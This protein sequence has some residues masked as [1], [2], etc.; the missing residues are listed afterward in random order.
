MAAI[1]AITG[2]SSDK[3]L[4]TVYGTAIK[5]NAYQVHR[6]KATKNGSTELRTTHRQ[7]S[8][9]LWYQPRTTF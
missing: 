6:K 2:Y 4:G 3:G 7:F 1:F 8:Q 9:Q 5:T